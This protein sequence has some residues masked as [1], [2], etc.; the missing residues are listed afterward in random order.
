MPASAADL[1]ALRALEEHFWE[2][3]DLLLKTSHALAAQLCLQEREAE[4]KVVCK[5]IP[6]PQQ[7]G[8][9]E[10]VIP[11]PQHKP[12][13]K[14]VNRWMT[15]GDLRK[16]I[17][18]KTGLKQWQVAHVLKLLCEIAYKEIILN[19]KFVI[20]KLVS[21]KVEHK[22]ATKASERML[23]GKKVKVPAKPARK[24]VKAFAAKALKR[25][26]KAQKAQLSP[27]GPAE[28]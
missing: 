19:G 27:E 28:S 21:F 14:P 16:A 6:W 11:W 12:A 25:T 1:R 20:R 5:L 17:A 7:E 4:Q 10:Q 2:V 3:N 9:A 18:L 23:N 13:D 15:I 22:P 26:L 24:V 8:E